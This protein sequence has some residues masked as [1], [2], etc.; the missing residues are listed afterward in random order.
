MYC[1]ECGNEVS[2]GD[3]C[4]NCGARLT[5]L[6]NMKY[7]GFWIR[8]VAS[9]ID[10]IIIG[11]PVFIIAFILGIFSLFSSNEVDTS[12]YEDSSFNLI[13]FPLFWFT[14]AIYALLCGHARIKVARNA[15]ENDC[16]NQS[17]GFEGATNF[18]WKVARSLFCNHPIRHLVYRIYYGGIHGQETILT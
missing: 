7:A 18:I 9:F 11:I 17:N 4:A 2:S 5:E 6:E 8:F 3:F 15:R 14:N 16:R 10:G 13:S 1:K 12:V